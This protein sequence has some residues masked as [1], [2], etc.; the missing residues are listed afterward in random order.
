M[1]TAQLPNASLVAVLLDESLEVSEHW[2]PLGAEDGLSLL[3]VWA[4]EPA[5]LLSLSSL[6]LQPPRPRRVVVAVGV[7]APLGGRVAVCARHRAAAG[8][9]VERADRAADVR[10]VGEQGAAGGEGV[11][12]SWWEAARNASQ[13][14]AGAGRGQQV[15]GRL[16]GGAVQ[17]QAAPV[18]FITVHW[19]CIRSLGRRRRVPYRWG[20][21]D[22][23]YLFKIRLIEYIWLKKNKPIWLD[24]LPWKHVFLCHFK[25]L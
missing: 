22:A 8:I 1:K 6:S 23:I 5:P 17:R 21:E 7:T 15:A 18:H 2:P 16:G 14:G 24:S 20:T 3:P 11:A 25:L 10:A 12:G 13:A 4:P 9:R 19:A